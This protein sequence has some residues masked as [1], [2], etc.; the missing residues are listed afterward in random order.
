[1][2]PTE[3]RPN[4]AIERVSTL[5]QA[6][7]RGD[8]TPYDAACAVLIALGLPLNTP[9]PP[10][11]APSKAPEQEQAGGVSTTSPLPP[12]SSSV[13]LFVLREALHTAS[14]PKKPGTFN[15]PLNETEE[16]M[17]RNHYFSK[18]AHGSSP[19]NAGEYAD[20]VVCN[21]RKRGIR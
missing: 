13:P 16:E 4:T 6:S 3:S 7:R 14:T 10:L 8:A 9:L 1:M 2:Q 11:P 12:P 18:L 20:E 15:P 19:E 21:V 5:I 17:W